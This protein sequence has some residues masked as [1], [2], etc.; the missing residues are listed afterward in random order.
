MTEVKFFAIYSQFFGEFTA[1]FK[2]SYW[3]AYSPFCESSKGL[4]LFC[5]CVQENTSGSE[6]IQKE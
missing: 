5:H 6:M 2:D 3:L 4:Y 1:N